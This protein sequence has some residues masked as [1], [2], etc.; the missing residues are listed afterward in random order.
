VLLAQAALAAYLRNIELGNCAI[1]RGYVEALGLRVPHDTGL[2][3]AG[4]PTT[5]PG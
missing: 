5:E 3:D 2:P 4:P 1:N